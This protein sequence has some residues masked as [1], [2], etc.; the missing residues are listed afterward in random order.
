M[1]QKSLLTSTALICVFVM[2]VSSSSFAQAQNTTNA[3]PP[4]TNINFTSATQFPIPTYNSTVSFAPGGSYTNASLDNGTWNFD[5][6]F[7]NSGTSALPNIMGVGFS[8]SAQNCN[9]TIT[10][11][12]A[13]NV[14]PPFP[15]E[16]D[17]SVAGGGSQTF[18]LHYPDYGLLSWIVYID[19]VAEPQN[20][21][22]TISADG[23]LTITG[24]VSDVGIH[25]AEASLT[26]FTPSDS[27]AIPAYNSTVN[28][29]YSGT[30]LGTATID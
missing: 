3:F 28:F 15:G 10:H 6:L 13:L 5:G 12:D 25:W 11:L 22:W 26:T 30:Y 8:V 9:V 14:V 7:V 16:L 2:L 20:N 24:A 1:N 18:D 29:A 27:F 23:T 19:G 21:G 17:Y 4:T